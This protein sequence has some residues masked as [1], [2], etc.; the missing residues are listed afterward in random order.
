MEDFELALRLR[1]AGWTCAPAPDAIGVHLGSA[2]HGNRSAFQRR[3]GGFGRGYLLRRYGVLRSRAAV[4]ALL[5]EAI[6]VAGDLV[7]SRDL[8]ALKGRLAGFRAARGR[9]RLPAPPGEAIDTS[10]GLRRSLD[11][12]RGVYDGSG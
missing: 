12:R 1:A 8:A 6:V 10:I 7:I 9:P 2:T 3:H 11:L 5:T 4:R